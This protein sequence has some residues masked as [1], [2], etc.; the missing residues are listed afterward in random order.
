MTTFIRFIQETLRCETSTYRVC[1][2][3]HTIAS[4]KSNVTLRSANAQIH[5]ISAVGLRLILN[6]LTNAPIVIQ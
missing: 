2:V 5:P 4:I 3:T 1:A 6:V